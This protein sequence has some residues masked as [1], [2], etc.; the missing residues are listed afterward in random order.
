METSL[1]RSPQKS[2]RRVS[3]ELEISRQS[4]HNLLRKRN[5]KPYIPRLFHALNDGDADRRVE[6]SEI[7]LDIMRDD[8]T[9]QDK[10]WWSDEACFKLNGHINR[11]NC[12][13]WS[14]DNPHVVLEKEV[15]LPGVTVW[16][17]MSSNGIIGPF[18]F[19][20][21][22]T[23]ELY[24]D[25]LKTFFFPQVQ[26]ERDIRF[27]QDGAPPHYAYCVR[28]WLDS[29][30][31]GRWIGRR[32]PIDW[33][34]R[35]PDLSLMDFF[36]W[37]ILKDMVYKEKPRT[38]PDLRRVIVEKFATIDLELCRKFCRSVPSRLLSCIE[39]NGKQFEQ[40]RQ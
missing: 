28:E 33:P 10:I 12:S 8:E 17:A 22:V 31:S 4:V 15:N 24:L 39:N 16:A 5:L 32:G 11:H 6:F 38:I 14:H 7:F 2:V 19:D 34:S 3:N 35:S 37:G 21:S 27:Q 36:L 9:F 30:F 18:F 29:N 13:Y 23:G 20:S 40:F 25:M 1:S 26:H